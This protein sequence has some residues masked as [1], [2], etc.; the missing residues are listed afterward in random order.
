MPFEKI[1]GIYIMISWTSGS[2]YVGAAR[3]CHLRWSFHRSELRRGIHIY[4]EKF[5]KGFQDGSLTF[6]LLQRCKPNIVRRKLWKI[7]QEWANCFPDRVN[8]FRNVTG[9]GR[10]GQKPSKATRTKMSRSRKGKKHSPEI[11]EKIRRALLGKKHTPEHRRKNSQAHLGKKKG[12]FTLEHREKIRQALLGQ[13]KT[14]EHVANW[15]KS[16]W[17]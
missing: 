9:K 10:A 6:F 16:R 5:M 2:H 8:R 14:P 1:C 12:P 11:R 3:N 7:E 15:R 4:Q 13:K 17:G